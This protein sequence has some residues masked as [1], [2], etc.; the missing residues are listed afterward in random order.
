MLSTA[1]CHADKAFGEGSGSARGDG[2]GRVYDRPPPGLELPFL[3]IP[4]FETPF[5]AEGPP[6]P[7]K[8]KCFVLKM[9]TTSAVAGI[10]SQ[11]MRCAELTSVECYAG[12][13]A[14]L[15]RG[16]VGEERKGWCRCRTRL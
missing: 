11:C 14:I 2:G 8:I 15:W 12:G 1:V 3:K 6:R 7:R 10:C 5:S 13:S 9:C 16:V 4:F